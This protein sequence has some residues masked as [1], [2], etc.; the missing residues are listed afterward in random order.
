MLYISCFKNELWYEFTGVEPEVIDE[1]VTE[2]RE[3]SKLEEE[4]EPETETEAEAET[5]KETIEEPVTTEEPETEAVEEETNQL[6]TW[7]TAIFIVML[8]LLGV[9]IIDSV[10][11]IVKRKKE[12]KNK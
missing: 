4:P 3:D 9:F 8:C 1:V 6:P 2:I 11:R 5:V 10:Y 12:E 7:V